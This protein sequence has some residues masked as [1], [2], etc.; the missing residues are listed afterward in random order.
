MHFPILNADQSPHSSQIS[1][2]QSIRMPRRS[3]PPTGVK[4]NA[5]TVDCLA[6]CPGYALRLYHVMITTALP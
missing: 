2:M 6:G 4:M 1:L 5:K 3:T